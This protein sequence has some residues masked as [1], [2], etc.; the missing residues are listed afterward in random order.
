MS[1]WDQLKRFT[2]IDIKHR[3]SWADH[4]LT[5]LGHDPTV[6]VFVGLEVKVA[7]TDLFDNVW[8]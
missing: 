8:C 1:T 5:V 2:L 4:T 3:W 7:D 6:N